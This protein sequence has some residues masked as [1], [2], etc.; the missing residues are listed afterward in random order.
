M[1]QNETYKKFRLRLLQEK[2]ELL[3][4]LLRIERDSLENSYEQYREGT[5]D[6]D[7]AGDVYE[8][9]LIL[10]GRAQLLAHLSEVNNALKRIRNNT[11]GTSIVSGKPIPDERLEVLPW[12][13]YLV[14]EEKYLK[15]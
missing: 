15:R 9:E 8:E 7:V 13:T 11:Y 2:K 12:A 14:E 4:E 10:T 3:A 6:F 1:T 5:R